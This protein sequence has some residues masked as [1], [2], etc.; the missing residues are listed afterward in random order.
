MTDQQFD[1]DI[2]KAELKPV[3]FLYGEETYLVSRAQ[4]RLLDV[5]VDPDTKDF[6]LS[7][8][9]GAECTAVQ[10]VDAA[11]TLPMFAERR[12]VLL[13]NIDKLP[14]DGHDRMLAYLA[15]PAPDTCLI[16]VAT[17]PDMRRKLYAEL[18]KQP[19]SLECKK[20]YDN[21]LA[22]FVIAEA[23]TMGKRIEKAAADVLVF[24]IGNQLQSLITQLEKLVI[25]VGGRDTITVSDV[26]ASVSSVKEF[27][28]FEFAAAVGLKD[29]EQA[30]RSL[31]TL[32]RNASDSYTVVGS[33]ASHM[34]RLWRVRELM[35]A[36]ASNDQIVAATKIPAFFLKDAL[37]Q[38]KNYRCSELQQVI[39]DLYEAD[40]NIKS[41]RGGGVTNVLYQ[42]VYQIIQPQSLP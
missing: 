11:S 30:L 36:A 4:K 17:K 18:K 25:V 14:T 3:Y 6:N 19:G 31:D 13:K 23:Q 15:D 37:L 35:D 7:V 1:S 12:V 20:I 27:T 9:Y 8:F 5:A 32:L 16:C 28:A 39:L 10:V 41:G 29:L 34:R 21:R 42:L 33:L 38:A 2:R 22:P 26:Q 40:R 24:L